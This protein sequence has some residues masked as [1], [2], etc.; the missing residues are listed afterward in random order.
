MSSFCA[1]KE[2]SLYFCQS[3]MLKYKKGEVN[4]SLRPILESFLLAVSRDAQ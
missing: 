1:S 2:S 3:N 4:K